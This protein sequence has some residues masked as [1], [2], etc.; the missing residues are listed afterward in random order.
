MPLSTISSSTPSHRPSPFHSSDSITIALQI[1]CLQAG[2]YVALGISLFISMEALL[3][4]SPTL[5]SIF[6]AE[7]GHVEALPVVFAHVLTAPFTAVLVGQ[8]AG[9]TGQV[10]DQVATLSTIHLILRIIFFS[11]F[12]STVAFWAAV[13][14]DAVVM[15]IIG[16]FVARRRELLEL[17]R[18]VGSLN[19]QE[20]HDHH[21]DENNSSAANNQSSSTE[22]RNA[23]V[24]DDQN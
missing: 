14:F 21:H 3:G 6:A 5:A 4:R 24:S 18:A 13:A 12:P 15:V 16:E 2:F 7:P 9:S 19:E 8:V 10:F 20:E 17:R 22:G 23:V 1:V 11:S